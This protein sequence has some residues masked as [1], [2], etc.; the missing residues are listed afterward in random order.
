MGAPKRPRRVKKDRTAEA[1]VDYFA[2]RSHN[3]W[4]RKFHLA[5]P[6]EKSRPR[7]R[8]RG[9][10][11]VDINQPWTKLDP[12]AKDDNKVAA[13]DALEAITRFPKDREAAADYVHKRWIARNKRDPNQPKALFKPY[14]QLPEAEKDKDRAHVDNMR[15]ALASVRNAAKRPK[16]PR[17]ADKTVRIK[18]KDWARLEASARAL[19]ARIGAPVSAETLLS[20]GVEAIIV[21]CQVTTQTTRSKR[22]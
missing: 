22:P 14:K 3:A 17:S 9:G 10:I 19:S 1:A 21:V 6:G 7:M 15:A 8:M 5:Q 20:A 13:Y 12:K 4:R 2:A 11:M 18:A 16:A